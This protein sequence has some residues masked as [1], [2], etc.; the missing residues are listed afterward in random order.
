MGFVFYLY[1]TIFAQCMLKEIF[2]ED[3]K[4][5]KDTKVSFR[6]GLNII[7]GKNG[8]GK[9]N[10]LE[11]IKENIHHEL[12][13]FIVSKNSN[14]ARSNFKYKFKYSVEGAMVDLDLEIS[15]NE[16]SPEVFS[17]KILLSKKSKDKA[18][19]NLT[20]SSLKKPFEIIEEL[21]STPELSVLL[22]VFN[23]PSNLL[24]L[25]SAASIDMSSANSENDRFFVNG[26]TD[27]F[28]TT[29][30]LVRYLNAATLGHK[31]ANI[32]D[33]DF[34]YLKKLINSTF[35]NYL[36]V[37]EIDKYISRY[38]PI[39]QL[40]IG[41]N[42]NFYKSGDRIHCENLIIEFNIDGKWMPWNYLSDGTKRLFYIIS[43][44]CVYSD[45]VIL[46]EEP[47]L[48]IHPHQLYELM[49]FL[50]EQS[51]SKQI[52]ISTHSPLVLDT[53]PA[54]ELDR[55]IIAKTVDGKSQFE[56]LTPEQVDTA[57]TY[58]HEV[59]NLSAYWL[60]SDLEE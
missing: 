60:H 21:Y 3:Y 11:F 9:S 51:E 41:N 38:S 10:L 48:G 37:Y 53:L 15:P 18:I 29:S 47:E 27:D 43:S 40:R 16:K 30:T 39:K 52:I 26:E 5:L 25:N 56:H 35:E 14:R 45:G 32:Q 46:I 4:S 42:I 17:Q 31:N 55:I 58:I 23:L 50:K 54:N 59:G 1:R 8:S 2:I 7:I 24:W 22:L 57:K 20:L 12:L 44:T 36:R 28:I 49:S 6:E 34:I 19:K 13:E 33:A